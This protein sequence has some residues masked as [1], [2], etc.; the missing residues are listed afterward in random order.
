[1]PEK[2]APVFGRE[3]KLLCWQCGGWF[4]TGNTAEKGFTVNDPALVGYSPIRGGVCPDCHRYNVNKSKTKDESMSDT[5][6]LLD[7]LC[8]AAGLD[9]L[10]HGLSEA[11][12]LPMEGQTGIVGWLKEMAKTLEM[13]AKKLRQTI[14]K[15]EKVKG[16]VARDPDVMSALDTSVRAFFGAQHLATAANLIVMFSAQTAGA[17]NNRAKKQA[18][19]R[20]NHLKAKYPSVMKIVSG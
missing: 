5:D 13:E 15:L 20:A 10:E 8:E 12:I 16:E 1:M 2:S 18:T 9:A 3:S 6:R 19:S 11:Q 17:V 14:A 4:T 7:D